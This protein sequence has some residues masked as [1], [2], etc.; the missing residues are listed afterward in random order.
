[1]RYFLEKLATLGATLLYLAYIFGTIWAVYYLLPYCLALVFSHTGGLLIGIAVL[2]LVPL[3]PAVG[4]LFSGKADLPFWRRYLNHLANLGWQLASVAVVLVPAALAIVTMLASGI[5]LVLLAGFPL[6][7]V[8]QLGWHLGAKL[9]GE[10]LMRLGQLAALT[11]ATAVGAGITN[12]LSN[13]LIDRFAD[14]LK[15]H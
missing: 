8:Q 14:L 12:H 3:F 11:G 15:N 6:Y 4:E 13:K 10:D 5:T 1:M 7:L 2:I 9:T